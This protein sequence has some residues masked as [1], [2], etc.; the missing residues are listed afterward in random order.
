M[1]VYK[2]FGDTLLVGDKGQQVN[3]LIVRKPKKG[4][5]YVDEELTR[6]IQITSGDEY[7]HV[8]MGDI[9]NGWKTAY[10]WAPEGREPASGGNC[11]VRACQR[12]RQLYQ[13]SA[14]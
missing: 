6:Q 13:P 5:E 10:V 2:D 1:Q 9:E 8:E 11:E 14:L 4:P 3:A 12:R 7:L